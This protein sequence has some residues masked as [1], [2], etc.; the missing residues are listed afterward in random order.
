MDYTKYQKIK[1]QELEDTLKGKY[2]TEKVLGQILTVL[3]PGKTWV[4]DQTFKLPLNQSQKFR[5]RPDYCCHELKMCVEFDGP[6]HFMKANVILADRNKNL[7]LTETGY[8]LIRIPYFIQLNTETIKYFFNI[9]VSFNYNH[10]HGFISKNI[11]L[12]SSF[13]EQGIWKFKDIMRKKIILFGI[14][15]YLN[16]IKIN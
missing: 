15:Y 2:L 14:F 13:C 1:I 3:Y 9:R 16:L 6:D 10:N 4:H 5:F 11:V 12:P 7:K 8:T